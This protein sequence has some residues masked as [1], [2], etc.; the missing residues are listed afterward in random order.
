MPPRHC[1]FDCDEWSMN[2]Q[3]IQ[4][5]VWEA[6]KWGRKRER[7]KNF[8]VSVKLFLGFSLFVHHHRR[9]RVFTTLPGDG[10][11]RMDYLLMVAFQPTNQPASQVSPLCAKFNASNYNVS[12][13]TM[14][15]GKFF[16]RT[17]P[18]KNKWLEKLLNVLS[19]HNVFN[20]IICF[21]C[22]KIIIIFTYQFSQ[23]YLL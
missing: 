11:T 12:H 1:L 10:L 22:Y 14:R 16:K 17:Q 20:Y 8:N 18:H 15:D 6:S 9:W 3:I 7:E 2:L 23:I 4:L 13:F 5:S 21:M 19:S